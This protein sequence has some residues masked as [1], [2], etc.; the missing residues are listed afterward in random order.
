MSDS[1]SPTP[2]DAEHPTDDAATRAAVAAE[3]LAELR[4]QVSDPRWYAY[5]TAR[6]LLDKLAQVIGWD[7]LYDADLPLH[8]YLAW[9]LFLEERIP[10]SITRVREAIAIPANERPEADPDG[11]EDMVYWTT[12]QIQDGLGQSLG[13][14]RRLVIELSTSP[15]RDDDTRTERIAQLCGL[16]ADVAGKFRGDLRKGVA[17]LIADG[18]DGDPDR[19]EL[20]LFPDKFRELEEGMRLKNALVDVMEGFQGSTRRLPIADVLHRWRSGEVRGPYA[21]LEVKALHETLNLVLA[22][23]HR[24]GLY[25][26]SYQRLLACS[27]EI[28][29]RFK[30]LGRALGDPKAEGTLTRELAAVL[31]LDILAEMLGDDRGLELDLDR[32]DDRE[33]ARRLFGKRKAISD[34]PVERDER[35]RLQ[36]TKAMLDA[37]A[38]GAPAPG[39]GDED[40][41][42]VRRAVTL[43][44]GKALVDRLRGSRLG[45]DLDDLGHLHQLVHGGEDGL[46]SYLVLLYGQVQRRD[47]HLLAS[48]DEDISLPE[49]HLALQELRSYLSRL[50]TSEGWWNLTNAHRALRSHGAL[51]PWRD[52]TSYIRTLTRELG[53]RLIRIARYREIAGVDEDTVD[54]FDKACSLLSDVEDPTEAREDVLR[55]LD[56]IVEVLE[57]LRDIEIVLAPPTEEADLEAFLRTMG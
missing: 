25:V 46:R 19:I 54:R 38:Q 1:A 21:L 27:R 43:L 34:L 51:G 23:E 8:D 42:L 7:H 35:D 41:A 55:A 39:F 4:A 15:P 57:T 40:R 24:M 32:A 18:F 50:E 5:A 22:P 10:A 44:E 48:G 37:E 30:A 29:T 26:D 47:L 6:A 2:A 56:C 12:R 20:T 53:R 17:F 9:G 45:D 49:K 31:D 28:G 14:L 52:V 36:A 11:L 16:I 33:R 3:A 13:M